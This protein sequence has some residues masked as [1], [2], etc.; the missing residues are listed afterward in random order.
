MEQQIRNRKGIVVNPGEDFDYAYGLTNLGSL[1][2]AIATPAVDARDRTSILAL[3][4]AGSVLELQV[5][6][7]KFSGY[8][9][10]SPEPG[11][12]IS[13][14]AI[15]RSTGG[16]DVEYVVDILAAPAII[17]ANIITPGHYTRRATITGTEGQQVADVGNFHDAVVGSNPAWLTDPTDVPGTAQANYIGSYAFNVHGNVSFVFVPTTLPS[18]VLYI[19]VRRFS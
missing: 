16:E 6:D 11:G 9:I 3:I 12:S 19:D 4:E 17:A 5:P 15:L 8:D 2:T 14:E 7:N 13:Y 1:D 18:G 10:P